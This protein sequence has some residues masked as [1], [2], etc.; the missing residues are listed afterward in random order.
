MLES[1]GQTVNRCCVQ[2]WTRKSNYRNTEWT[3]KQ[4]NKKS[5]FT[6]WVKINKIKLMSKSL[7][8]N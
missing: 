7:K 8:Y 3:N 5:L 2:D 4:T 6:E 1:S